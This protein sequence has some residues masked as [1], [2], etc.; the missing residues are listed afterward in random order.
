MASPGSKWNFSFSFILD[1]TKCHSLPAFCWASWCAADR[2]AVHDSVASIFPIT[3]LVRSNTKSIL[4]LQFLTAKAGARL[5]HC[6]LRQ[7]ENYNELCHKRL[8]GP[9][10]SLRKSINSQSERNY[11]A[12]EGEGE[13]TA[14][15]FIKLKP[16]RRRVDY[17]WKR[18]KINCKTTNKQ[19]KF[20]FTV[21]H[22][23]L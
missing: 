11:G 9:G 19:H 22:F 18:S 6:V 5:G 16:H 20:H 2:L 13:L 4:I 8:T 3:S 7:M 1:F 23:Q 10:A 14:C 15:Q 12:A 21:E 17:G